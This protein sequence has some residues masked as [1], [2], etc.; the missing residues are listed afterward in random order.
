[1]SAV[2]SDIPT[3]L[4]FVAAPVAPDTVNFLLYGPPKTG[5]STGAATSP[6]PILWISAEGPNALDYAR[7]VARQRKTAI[8]EVRV[9]R[10]ADTRQLLR[11]VIMHVRSGAEPQPRT[12][13][14][15]TVAKVRERLIS[16]I[17]VPGAR[18][19]IQQFGEVAKILRE[20]VEVMRDA[21][22]NL[23]LVAH[24]DV[25]DAE[26]ERIVQPLIG[27]SLTQVIPGEVDVIA[28]T[29]SFKDEETGSRRYVGQLVEAKGRIAGDRSGGLGAVR[30]LDL[31]EWLETYRAALAVDAPWE[32]EAPVGPL[33]DA[34]PA[35]L[36]PAAASPAVPVLSLANRAKVLA[37]I[38]ASGV[39]LDAILDAVEVDKPENLTAAHAKRIRRLLD[40]R[41]AATRP[42]EIPAGTVAMDDPRAS[43]L[44][45]CPDGLDTRPDHT[46]DSC[47]LVGHGLL[48]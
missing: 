5:K 4:L 7:K 12:V 47:P 27:G 38:D 34:P 25:Q 9:Q 18:N 39:S 11:D 40:Q 1:M 13:V 20:F 46:V 28:Y 8:H 48:F 41:A 26:G 31:S 32:E 33:D 16:E 36:E 42:D 19:T 14:V 17:V 30:D 45:L 35:A 43:E 15:D 24:Q 2:E 29:H 23:V 6:G 37:A 44:C 3:G 21:P 10:G 22:V